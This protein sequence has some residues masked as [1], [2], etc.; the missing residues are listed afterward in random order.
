MC[1]IALD[2]PQG[3][4]EL[5]WGG[6]CTKAWTNAELATTTSPRLSTKTGLTYTVARE[7]DPESNGL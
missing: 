3:G 2:G 1:G 4:V 5:Q 6:G 7:E